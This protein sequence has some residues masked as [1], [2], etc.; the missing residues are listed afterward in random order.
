MP[1]GDA[2]AVDIG[3]SESPA[4][5][6]RRCTGRKGFVDFKEIDVFYGKSALARALC[7]ALIGPIPM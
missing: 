7:D 5:S 1:Q 3:V 2:A 4:P 6:G